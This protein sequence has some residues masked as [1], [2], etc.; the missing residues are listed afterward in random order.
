MNGSSVHCSDL[1]DLTLQSEFHSKAHC[2]GST[3][4]DSAVLPHAA[5]TGTA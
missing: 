3:T 5:F 4:I 1:R 2:F